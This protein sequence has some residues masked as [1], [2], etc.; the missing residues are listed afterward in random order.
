MAQWIKDLT[1]SLLSLGSQFWH[2]FD[3]WLENFHML[4]AE[5]KKKKREREREHEIPKPMDA[6]KVLIR[7]KCIDLNSYI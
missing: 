1:L 5:P 3:L 4:Q 2:D 6:A 7:G